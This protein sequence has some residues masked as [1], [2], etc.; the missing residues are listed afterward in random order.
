MRYFI[1]NK[2][3]DMICQFTQ[4]VDG[5]ITL[6]DLDFKFDKDIYPVG[7]LDLDSEGLL[8]LTNDRKLTH[9]LLA[10]QFQHPRTY[11]AQVE[12]IALEN[13]LDKL[14]SGVDIKLDKKK[15][16]CTLPAKAR[17]ITDIDAYFAPTQL[18]QRVPP[19]RPSGRNPMSW[20]EI[21]LSEGKNRQVRKMCSAIGHPCLRLIRVG[22]VNLKLGDLQPGQV[23][24]ITNEEI[25]NSAFSIQ[26]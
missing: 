2:P 1:T 3:Y 11:L 14:R 23:R 4:E 20:I 24:E 25:Q 5:Q 7:R 17:N 10:P 9:T 12:G 8:L 6:A 26:H 15:I 16:H 18:W 13:N 21:T 19:A 22:I